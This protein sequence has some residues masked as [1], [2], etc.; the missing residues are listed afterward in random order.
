M[1][2]ILINFSLFAAVA[3]T[4]GS[5]TK[6][7]NVSPITELSA[8]SAFK[9]LADFEKALGGV[10]TD[11]RAATYYNGN[12]GCDPDLLTD[13]FF[14]TTES[15]GNQKNMSNWIYLSNEGFVANSWLSPYVA[16]S[17]V[18]IVIGKIDAFKAENVQKYNRILGQAHALRAL[19]HFDLLKTFADN[20][21]RNSTGAGIP[22]K[23]NVDITTP[24]RNTVKEVYDLIYDDL[25]KAIT[26]LGNVDV[27]VN[28]ATSR[29]LI[30][31][32]GAKAI[33]ARV[34]LYAKDYPTA[35][36][37]ATDVI[38][39]IPVAN[40]TDYPGVWKDA[41]VKEVIWAIQNNSGEG[42]PST[43]LMSFRFNRNT[44]AP[45]PSLIG[46]YDQANDVRFGAF[47]FIRSGTTYGL[48]KFRGRGAASDNL[49][50]FKVLHTGEM[51]LIRAEAYA[52]S[53]QDG[54]AQTDLNTLKSN[55]INGFV[56]QALTGQALKDEI[57]IERRRELA[58]E[59]HRWFDLKRSTRTVNRPMGGIPAFS[60]PVRD[61]L[62]SSS[63]KWVFPIPE[64]EM[65]ANPSMV[66]NPGY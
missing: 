52:N 46:L 37:N 65:R 40:R 43:T 7:L 56:N 34:A 24:G 10:Y 4:I 63:P 51:Y 3:V 2:R 6:S 28:T 47:Y 61:L 12:Y 27:P 54:P 50:N 33:L 44:Y 31:I 62:I 66:Q 5:C 17:D 45:H 8:G 35:I 20:L 9:T 23:T 41:N 15:L 13:N 16:I 42:F 58:G 36:T 30:D 57:A 60:N 64:V 21:D 59:G 18:N 38:N 48:Q 39:A 11:F 19:A 26:L 29:A 25:G 1:K 32:N 22:I 14:E 49:V 55:R 53:S